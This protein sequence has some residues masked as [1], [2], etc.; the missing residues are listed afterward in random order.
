MN[1]G[2][3]SRRARRATIAVSPGGDADAGPLRYA[4]LVPDFNVLIY[5]EKL[6]MDDDGSVTSSLMTMTQSA[7]VRRSAGEN[8]ATRE[9]GSG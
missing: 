2:S 8:A 3:L 7:D 5:N 1:R 6:Q 9:G 4:G